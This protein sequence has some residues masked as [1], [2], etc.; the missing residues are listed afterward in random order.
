LTTHE[1]RIGFGYDAPVEPGAGEI[2]TVAA[3]YE[4]ARTL[5]WLRATLQTLGEVIDLPWGPDIVSRIAAHDLDVIF[6]ITEATGSRNRESLMPALA[7]ARG[8]PCTG[9]DAVGLGL[10]LDKYLTKVLTG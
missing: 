2:E 6:N 1:L 8:I 7:E 9:S 4:D 3:E 10:S 5:S